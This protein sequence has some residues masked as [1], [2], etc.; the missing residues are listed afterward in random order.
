MVLNINTN[1]VG[2]RIL[3]EF[4]ELFSDTPGLYNRREITLHVH[5]G[6]EPVALGATHGGPKYSQLD[7]AHAYMQIQVAEESRK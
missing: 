5:P 2:E 3:A 4:E 6:T 1:N 7:L